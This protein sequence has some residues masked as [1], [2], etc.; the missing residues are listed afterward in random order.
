MVKLESSKELVDLAMLRNDLLPKTFPLL[1][2][3]LKV[4]L[5]LL[6]NVNLTHIGHLLVQMIENVLKESI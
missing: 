3:G 6:R 4:L 5:K 1:F 2:L